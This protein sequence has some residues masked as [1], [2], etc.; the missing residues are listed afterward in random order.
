MLDH[1][2]SF[3]GFNNRFSLRIEHDLAVKAVSQPELLASDNKLTVR[4]I[5]Y[6]DTASSRPHNNFTIFTLINHALSYTLVQ[7][8]SAA[9]TKP[10]IEISAGLKGPRIFKSKLIFQVCEHKVSSIYFRSFIKAVSLF[11]SL[12]DRL[13]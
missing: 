2:D 12:C 6:K 10:N 13:L 5:P 1:S 4:T 8:Q 9:F 3:T 7:V 11:W